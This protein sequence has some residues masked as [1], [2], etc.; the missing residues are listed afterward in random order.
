MSQHARAPVLLGL[1]GVVL[2]P[3]AL[4]A[5]TWAEQL[6][7]PP[8]T[9]V[10]I[11]HADDAGMFSD[12]NQAI[13]DLLVGNPNVQ[14]AS[15]MPPCKYFLPFRDWWQNNPQFDVGIHLTLNSEWKEPQALRWGPVRPAAQVPKLLVDYP[16]DPTLKKDHV[17]TW[18][19]NAPGQ[20]WLEIGAQYL[21]GLTP[22]LG[23]SHF[24]SHMGTVWVRGSYYRNYLAL[25]RVTGIPS[26]T[27]RTRMRNVHFS[28][29][30]ILEPK[31]VFQKI[32]VYFLA[33]SVRNVQRD[34]E[35]DHGWPLPRLDYYCRIPTRDSYAEVKAGFKEFVEDKLPA[36]IT[37]FFFHPNYEETELKQSTNDWQRRTWDAELFEDQE[38]KDFFTNQGILFS[39]WTD[40]KCRWECNPNNCASPW[41]QP[42]RCP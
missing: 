10:L 23:P 5:D 24:D 29:K 34:D 6:G 32:L 36:G 21:E 25:G 42:A 8:D 9:K 13:Q 3:A 16:W 38:I 39:N 40:I 15:A 30:S 20:V 28:A 31:G 37:Q 14:S 4:R 19:A 2:P 17:G 1:L 22:G 26:V 12:G 11:L 27:V 18:L 41:L 7:F 35:N 33:R